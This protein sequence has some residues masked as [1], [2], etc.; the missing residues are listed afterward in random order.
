[1]AFRGE[2]KRRWQNETSGKGN[3]E[4]REI[5]AAW[6]LLAG[7]KRNPL[8]QSTTCGAR[9]SLYSWLTVSY[10][11]ESAAVSQLCVSGENHWITFQNNS[12]DA[13][14]TPVW[15]CSEL[16]LKIEDLEQ[17]TKQLVSHLL[18]HESHLLLEEIQ[19][20][21]PW[22]T[23]ILKDFEITAEL[24]VECSLWTPN[25]FIIKLLDLF[26]F[27]NFV[28][29]IQRS[30]HLFQLFSL[31]IWGFLA[32][33]LLLGITMAFSFLVT[34]IIWDLLFCIC[35][36]ILCWRWASIFCLHLF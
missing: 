15:Q 19:G 16:V 4:N 22:E 7:G 23:K 27:F 3:H 21:V 6:V 33:S 13:S 5:R 24:G 34:L 29:W 36:E 11:C 17:Q 31:W 25:A 12:T 2:R 28:V 30:F 14:K 35:F 10:Q 8:S 18:C 9:E 1:M 32:C 20:S 26:Y